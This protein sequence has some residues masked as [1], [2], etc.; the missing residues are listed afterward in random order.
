VSDVSQ[1]PGWWIASD[2]KWYPPE[3][4]PD[5]TGHS[6][7]VVEQSAPPTGHS[8]V[9]VEQAAPATGARPSRWR[10]SSEAAPS[11]LI[12][13]LNEQLGQPTAASSPSRTAATAV[14]P[15]ATAPW[16]RRPT[17]L[18]A[19]GV[20]V[21]VALAV[22]ALVVALTSSSPVLGLPRGTT[23]ATIEIIDPHSGSPSFSGTMDG[24]ALTGA[25]SASA[26]SSL[27]G[28]SATGSP[29]A[30]SFDYRG[31]LGA[32]SYVLNISLAGLDT[33]AGAQSGQ[34]RFDVSGTYG[35]QRISGTAEFEVT[36]ATAQALTVPFTGSVGSQRITGVATA[37]QAG[38]TIEVTARLTVA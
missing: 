36:S 13:S 25:L 7:A 20:V 22:A 14:V 23:T 11:E 30:L 6:E 2:G 17:M 35:S 18:W 28:T 4:H 27:G 16:P 26:S 29:S 10:G 8:E 5:R 24:R 9:A 32:E 33:Q 37:I 31:S 3:S 1:G 21:V 19:A 34:L 15:A 12:A 38:T